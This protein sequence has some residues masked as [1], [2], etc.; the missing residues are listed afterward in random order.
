MNI[1]Y[2][3][4]AVGAVVTVIAAVGVYSYYEMERI[5]QHEKS[6]KGKN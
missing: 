1:E 6:G 4:G 5:A 3:I 2:F